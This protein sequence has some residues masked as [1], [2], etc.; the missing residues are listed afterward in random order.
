MDSEDEGIVNPLAQ[1]IV[2]LKC[3]FGAA[4]VD[5]CL[6][7]LEMWIRL[8]TLTKLPSN[9]VTEVDSSAF[10]T[11]TSSIANLGQCFIPYSKV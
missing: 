6:C 3:C 7:G 11:E 9:N 2:R 8:W 4:S 5:I 1:L 10:L